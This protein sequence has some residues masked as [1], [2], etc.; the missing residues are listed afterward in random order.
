MSNQVSKAVFKAR[1][2]E[3]LRQVEATG[4]SLV[5]T[6]RGRPVVEVRPFAV[7]DADPLAQLRG[8]VIA[9]ADPTLPIG[10]DEWERSA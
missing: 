10:A 1:V 6:H 3:L 2:L 8:S 9:Y 4:E 5:V 7:P